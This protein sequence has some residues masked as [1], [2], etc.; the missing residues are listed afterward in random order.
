MLLKIGY[1]KAPQPITDAGFNVL[2]SISVGAFFIVI[3][4]QT[5]TIG[6]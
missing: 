5:L 6:A 3:G 4:N 1:G 2:S